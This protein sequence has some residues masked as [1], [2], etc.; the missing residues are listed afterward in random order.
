MK[1]YEKLNLLMNLQNIPNNRL[2]KALSVDPSLISRWRNGTRDLARH[3]EY[4]T[5]I[6]H[7][8]ANQTSNRDRLVEIMDLPK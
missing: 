5:S 3:S 2:A 1:F 8:F 4:V 7:Y 6:A